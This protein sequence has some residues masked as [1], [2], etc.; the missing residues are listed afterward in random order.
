MS[1]VLFAHLTLA[2]VFQQG[3]IQIPFKHLGWSAFA[4]PVNNFKLLT[5]YAKKLPLRCLKG[6]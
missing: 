4:Y 6:F 1:R 2:L 5:V 3:H